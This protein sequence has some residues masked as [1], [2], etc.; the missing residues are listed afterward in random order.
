[1]ITF[2][3]TCPYKYS[4]SRSFWERYGCYSYIKETKCDQRKRYKLPYICFKINHHMCPL[5]SYLAP[6]SLS[7]VFTTRIG[8][9]NIYL[10]PYINQPTK[11]LEPV[12]RICDLHKPHPARGQSSV[13][14]VVQTL[15]SLEQFCQTRCLRLLSKRVCSFMQCPEK[16]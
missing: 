9:F 3:H 12:R 8:S 1:M 7:L 2:R 13:T 10:L 4:I 16:G 6:Y 5:D 14:S 15:T 11:F